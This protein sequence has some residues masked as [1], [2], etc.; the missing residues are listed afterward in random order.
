MG[1]N[2]ALILTGR[3]YCGSIRF[4]T[5]EQPLSVVYCHCESCRRATG[6]PVAAFA[7]LDET[8]V[9]FTPN[10]GRGVSVKAGVTRTFC[11]SCGSSLVGRYD[12]IPG[13]VYIS[14]GVIDQANVLVPTLHCHESE[15]LSWLQISDNLERS[16]TSARSKLNNLSK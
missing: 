7:G 8:V 3:C 10:E 11:S 5:T 16:N 1:D 6:A 13:Q 14:L 15:R 12:Y 9:T 2:N 4:S